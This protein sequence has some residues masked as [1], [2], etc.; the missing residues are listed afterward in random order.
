[1][2]RSRG[3]LGAL[4]LGILVAAAGA[5]AAET[6]PPAT[7]EALMEGMARAKG[8]LAEFTETKELALLSA[9]LETKGVL[10]FI[11]PDRMARRTLAP[12]ESTLVV[13]GKR[14]MFRDASGAAP[15]DLSGDPS[16]KEFVDNFTTIFRGDLAALRAKYEVRFAAEPPRWRLELVPR[17]AVLK[18][19]V[20][21]VTLAGEGE[22]M[23]EM[24][25]LER[26]GDRTT[27]RFGRVETDHV[28]TPAE[29]EALF[30][31]GE[32]EARR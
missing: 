11:P 23:R 22:A 7:I 1:M 30:G 4:A 21:S 26:D 25:L 2:R 5:R 15:V 14:V 31:A 27:T 19:F 8:V 16:A 18:R 9:P 17:D 20:A 3:R 13:D 29:V 10:H 32:A 24:V 12:A 28:Y 6:A